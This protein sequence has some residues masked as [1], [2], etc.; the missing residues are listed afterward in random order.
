V[1]EL[2]GDIRG[3][4]EAVGVGVV[5]VDVTH[6]WADTFFVEGTGD[7]FQCSRD[8][9]TK[10]MR[11]LQIALSEPVP[12]PPNVWCPIVQKLEEWMRGRAN[13]PVSIDS[14]GRLAYGA[15]IVSDAT[16]IMFNVAQEQGMGRDVEG[17]SIRIW[18][19]ATSEYGIPV[20]PFAIDKIVTLIAVDPQGVGHPLMSLTHT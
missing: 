13:T 19:G 20:R 9:A 17:W 7:G 8:E 6:S 11:M 3:N 16:R 10:L 12:A 4:E 5:S 1:P 18:E 14:H 2:G 15:A